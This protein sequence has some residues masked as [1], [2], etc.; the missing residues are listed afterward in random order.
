MRFRTDI[1]V[2]CCGFACAAEAY[3][4]KFRAVEIQQTFYRLPRPGTIAKWREQGPDGFAFSLK[5]WQLITHDLSCPS[6]RFLDEGYL[7]QALARCGGFRATEE[8]LDAWQ[9]L[10]GLA[11][12]LHAGYILFQSPPSFEPTAEHV[13]RMECFFRTI[14]RGRLRLA[15]APPDGWPHKLI[16][17]VCRTSRLIH[18][19]DPFVGPVLSRGPVYFRL[20]GI[21]GYR[22]RY[23]DAELMQLRRFCRRKS[24]V[25]FFNTIHMQEDARRFALLLPKR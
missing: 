12:V 16:S 18:C 14:D 10:R 17:D 1:K 20:Q 19:T 15:W 7:P 24:G 13:H 8:V 22:H 11:G 6:F 23:S 4:E 3:F 9:A 5:A 21:T 25:V 2:G